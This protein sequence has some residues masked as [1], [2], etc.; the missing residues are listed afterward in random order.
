MA[1]EIENCLHPAVNIATELLSSCLLLMKLSSYRWWLVSLLSK[2]DYNKGCVWPRGA[3]RHN[4]STDSVMAANTS[5]LH[6]TYLQPHTTASRDQT[7][8]PPRNCLT[9]VDLWV[10]GALSAFQTL[11][12]Y[13]LLLSRLDSRYSPTAGKMRASSDGSP[14]QYLHNIG[15]HHWYLWL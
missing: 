9:L 7:W 11:D 15:D 2:C 13:L 10:V 8:V 4:A 6:S 3:G 5:Q 1:E 12:I 14:G